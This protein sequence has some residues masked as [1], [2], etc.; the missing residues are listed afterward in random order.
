MCMFLGN[1]RPAEE[2]M[3][4]LQYVLADKS[5]SPS[6]PVGYLTTETRDVWSSVREKLAAAGLS[7]NPGSFFLHFLRFR[8]E[9]L[10]IAGV[11][12]LFMY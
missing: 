9:R 10:E 12:L 6:H 5:D 8:R 3:A 2:I 4:N 1:I 7:C 11:F